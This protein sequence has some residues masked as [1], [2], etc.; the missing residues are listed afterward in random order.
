MSKTK[1]PMWASEVLAGQAVMGALFFF[2]FFIGWKFLSWLPGYWDKDPIGAA[3][4]AIGA[5]LLLV[6]ILAG[7]YVGARRKKQKEGFDD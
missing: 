1:R 3:M 2:L 7:A 4:A 5:G 6:A